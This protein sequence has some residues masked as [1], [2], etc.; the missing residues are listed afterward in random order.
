MKKIVISIVVSIIVISMMIM[1]IVF[2]IGGSANKKS[3]KINDYYIFNSTD[4]YNFVDEKTGV[5]Y[6]IYSS[7]Y[8]G[9]ITPRLNP[10]GTVMVTKS[11]G[12]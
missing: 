5:N 6:L 8:R 10:D 11:K 1:G 12:K 3:R 4:V 2:L 9:G 7:K